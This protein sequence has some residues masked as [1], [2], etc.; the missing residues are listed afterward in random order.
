MADDTKP[1]GAPAVPAVP[2]APAAAAAPAVHAA[3][4]AA[5]TAATPARAPISLMSLVGKHPATALQDTD[6][7]MRLRRLLGDDFRKLS[8]RI[9]VATEIERSGTTIFGAGCMAHRC[10]IEEAAYAINVETGAAYAGILSGNSLKVYG[11]PVGMLPPP[12]QSWYA[13]RRNKE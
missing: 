13:D 11:G 3:K 2:T 4:P 8:D 5:P 1:E 6:V 7:K 9:D 12:L 10:S